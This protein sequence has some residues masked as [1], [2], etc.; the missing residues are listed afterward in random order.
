MGECC[1]SSFCEQFLPAR[2]H[3]VRAREVFALSLPES[4]KCHRELSY[5]TIHLA[6]T[7]VDWLV[8]LGC[9]SSVKELYQGKGTPEVV[10]EG[11]WTLWKHQGIKM[12]LVEMTCCA[13]TLC[14]GDVLFDAVAG[15]TSLLCSLLMQHLC[16]KTSLR[17]L[18]RVLLA[19][20]NTTNWSSVST[21][22]FSLP[23]AQGADPRVQPAVFF[24]F[25][26]FSFICYIGGFWFPWIQGSNPLWS[27]GL[28]FFLESQQ[29]HIFTM[30]A[31]DPM[32]SSPS[33]TLR[34][35]KN[36]PTS[37]SL[38]KALFT[39]LCIVYL[40]L[41][42]AVCSNGGSCYLFPLDP[43]D[44]LSVYWSILF[45]CASLWSEVMPKPHFWKKCFQF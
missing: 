17:Y 18:L 25:E 10:Y 38:S 31:A 41:F 27:N 39:V 4:S 8:S 20:K 9:S 16:C 19:E 40:S 14:I 33:T 15:C 26:I 23:N 37:S 12:G 22:P 29:L 5:S 42:C 34:L 28:F 45:L 1:C 2:V 24:K 6:L 21:L 11:F 7:W 36:N 30:P 32:L 3:W 13:W 44:V 35:A 43:A